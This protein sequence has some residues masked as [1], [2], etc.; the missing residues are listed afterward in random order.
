MKD[1]LRSLS[2]CVARSRASGLNGEVMPR[3]MA[4]SSPQV[5]TA[6]CRQGQSQPLLEPYLLSSL[7][8]GEGV[9]RVSHRAAPQWACGESVWRSHLSRPVLR[10]AA[11]AQHV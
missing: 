2:S 10:N 8:G 1:C 7:K 4:S 6:V 3:L 5:A 11:E 9:A